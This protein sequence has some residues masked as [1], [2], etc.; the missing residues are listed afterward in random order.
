MLRMSG[1]FD[2]TALERP[3]TCQAC[4]EPL[5]QCACPRSATGGVMLPKDQHAR[6]GREKRRKGKTVT[7]ITGLDPVASDWGAILGQLRSACAAGGTISQDRI[8]IQG[9]HRERVLTILRD[10]GYP[11]KMTGG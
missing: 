8:E 5:D 3:V 11:A 10:L 1:L 2:G 9:D 4:E 6:V 7:V